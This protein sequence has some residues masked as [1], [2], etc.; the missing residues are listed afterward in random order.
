MWERWG[1]RLW[2][3]GA[4]VLF[5]ADITWRKSNDVLLKAIVDEAVQT[6]GIVRHGVGAGSG[7]AAGPGG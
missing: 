7:P 4:T 1:E 2:L 5:C 3:S 6:A